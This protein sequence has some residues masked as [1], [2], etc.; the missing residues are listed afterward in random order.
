[1][2]NLNSIGDCISAVSEYCGHIWAFVPPAVYWFLLI[3]FTIYSTICLYLAIKYWSHTPA[4]AKSKSLIL[5][6]GMLGLWG[7][8]FNFV[9]FENGYSIS[10]FNDWFMSIPK[11]IYFYFVIENWIRVILSYILIFFVFS[12]IS[13]K[14]NDTDTLLPS[15][16]DG[17]NPT[18]G[19]FNP[20]DLI[21][22][23]KSPG[24]ISMLEQG[25]KRLVDFR[26]KVLRYK[27][28]QQNLSGENV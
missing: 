6:V 2:Q 27:S 18:R 19:Y 8:Y 10:A 16:G 28:G 22:F 17:L 7:I 13:H 11:R 20:D 14:A 3:M 4:K 5:F 23:E 15:L 25:K 21:S 12:V 24:R 9:V 1:M 26:E